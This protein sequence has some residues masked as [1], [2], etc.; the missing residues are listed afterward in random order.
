MAHP[1]DQNLIDQE[2]LALAE[3]EEWSNVEEQVLK[4][5]SR[6]NWIACGDSNSKYFHVQWK[7]RTSKN[8]IA[9][10]YNDNGVKLTDPVQVENEFISFFTKLM[11]KGGNVHKC[12]NA[13]VIHQGPCLTLQQKE[14]LVQEVTRVEILNVIKD[15]PHEKAPGVDDFPIEFFTKHWQEVGNDICES[16]KQFFATRKMHRGDSSSIVTLIPKVHQAMSK[17]KNP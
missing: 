15:M 4:Q 10:V 3:T 8:F 17:T 13:E 12:P 2:R 16:T 11:G 9:S 1:L 6:A 14:E 7:L 5:K